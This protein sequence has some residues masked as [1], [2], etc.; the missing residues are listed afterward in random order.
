M[1]VPK[2]KSFLVWMLAG[3]Y[4]ALGVQMQRVTLLALLLA[5]VSTSAWLFGGELIMQYM[6]QVR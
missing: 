6:G 4:S 3:R 2:K 5:A 1:P